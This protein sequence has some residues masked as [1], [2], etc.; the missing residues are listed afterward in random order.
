MLEVKN[1]TKS[2]EKTR[3]LR[4][5]SFAVNPAEFVCLTGPSGAGKSTII[6]LIIGAED[7]TSGSIEVDG[8]D[9]RKVPRRALQLFRRRVGVVFQDVKLLQNRTVAENIAFPLEAC[10]ATDSVIRKRVNELLEMVGL[11]KKAD[12]LPAALSG[13]EKT[14]VAIARSIVHKPIILLADEPTGNIDPEQALKIMK[15]FKDIHAEKTTIILATHDS[16]LVDSLHTRVI[17]L[18]DGAVVRDSVG[19]YFDGKPTHASHNDTKAAGAKVKI[20]SIGSL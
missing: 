5:V 13:G 16:N 17:R 14:R 1:V 20:T 6:S 11:T 2:Y 15:L 10:G 18:E 8:M 7:V 9:L 4:D 3:V 12:A 19:G